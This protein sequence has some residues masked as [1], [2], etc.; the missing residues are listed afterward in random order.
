MF[1]TASIAT[2]SIGTVLSTTA[3]SLTLT[4]ADIQAIVTAILAHPL[5]LTVPKFLALK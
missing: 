1:G 5:L 4:P 2:R 3:P